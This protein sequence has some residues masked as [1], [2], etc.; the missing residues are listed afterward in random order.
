M[1]KGEYVLLQLFGVHGECADRHLPKIGFYAPQARRCFA[2]SANF[3][4]GQ[5]PQEGTCFS[6]R[7]AR[8]SARAIESISA[9]L[10]QEA[11]YYRTARAIDAKIGGLMIDDTAFHNMP[12]LGLAPHYVGRA[13]M[14]K[15]KDVQIGG[16]QMTGLHKIHIR[17]RHELTRSELEC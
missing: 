5:T 10:H 6:C 17:E 11:S 14:Q 2:E 8:H 13:Q 7:G 16:M 4:K 1:V 9:D 12:P 15:T 3:V